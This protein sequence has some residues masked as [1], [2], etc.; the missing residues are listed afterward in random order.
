M[1]K[2]T[3]LM[4]AIGVCALVGAYATP[5]AAYYYRNTDGSWT[6]SEYSDGGCRIYYS[7]NAY[8]GETH[9]N[10]YGN[11]SNVAIGPDGRA[12]QVVPAPGAVVVPQY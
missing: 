5:A 7:H 11:C 6:N 12:M 10:R 4:A 1:R 2:F 8:D 9:V 3:G